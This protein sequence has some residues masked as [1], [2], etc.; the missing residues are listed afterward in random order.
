VHACLG[1]WLEPVVARGILFPRASAL[2]KIINI[3]ITQSENN[4]NGLGDLF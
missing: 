4:S 3:K 2:Y 1:V